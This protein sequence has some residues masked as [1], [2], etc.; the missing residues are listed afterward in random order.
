MK[1]INSKTELFIIS[2]LSLLC[3]YLYF[4]PVVKN[5]N[6]TILNGN[7][8][9]ESQVFIWNF[10]WI[11]HCLSE[12]K[13]IFF[14]DYT[15]G[16]RPHNL[17][18]H[19]FGLEQWLT[20]FFLKNKYIARFNFSLM[21]SHFLTIIF[22]YYL[23]RYFKFNLFL[24]LLGALLFNFS[25]YRLGLNIHLNISNIEFIPLFLLVLFKFYDKPCLKFTF[26][27]FIILALEYFASRSYFM[28][29]NMIL[30][31]TLVINFFFFK[32]GKE[33]IK[34]IIKLLIICY[35]MVLIFISPHL[36]NALKESYKMKSQFILRYS[37]TIPY[38][39]D[40]F[41]FVIPNNLA[42]YFS[43]DFQ[44]HKCNI[45]TGLSV[46]FSIFYLIFFIKLKNIPESHIKSVFWLFVIFII[47]SLGGTLH[48]FG[49]KIINTRY[50]IL[51]PYIILNRLPVFNSLQV[52]SRFYIVS[53]LCCIILFLYVIRIFLNELNNR[54]TEVFEQNKE[55]SPHKNLKS[56]IWLGYLLIIIVIIEY[57][58]YSRYPVYKVSIPDYYYSI[59]KES[60][61]F[62]ILELPVSRDN[63]AYMMYQT[64]HQKKLLGSGHISRIDY[65]SQL[66]FLNYIPYNAIKLSYYKEMKKINTELTINLILII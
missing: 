26:L 4:A 53:Q 45:Y 21:L 15:I 59:A 40:L 6:Q 50:G 35:I 61:D 66:D 28:F 62:S 12:G 34:L 38:C 65:E 30:L 13:N 23:L 10:W 19:T 63:V 31:F 46:I 42:K 39:A 60:G 16:L 27:L 36:I 17:Y 2:F 9:T 52:P 18:L 32:L 29:L 5:I 24:S 3:V 8:N 41:S 33:R 1:Y 22:T 51:L 44:L 64:V 7:L 37:R 49:S 14:S 58:P 55:V 20:T 25:S 56:N 48:I 43:L 11:D 54:N 47:L 57:F